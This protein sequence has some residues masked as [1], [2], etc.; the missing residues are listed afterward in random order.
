MPAGFPYVRETVVHQ[1][2]DWRCC[3][4]NAK[5]VSAGAGKPLTEMVFREADF[6]QAPPISG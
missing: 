3:Q 1:G 5:K 4:A 2:R 6:V